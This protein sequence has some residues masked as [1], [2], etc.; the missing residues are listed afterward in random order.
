MGT[1][2]P[3]QNL[4]TWRGKKDVGDAE[5]D[6]VHEIKMLLMVAYDLFIAEFTN[7]KR[8]IVI[9]NIF[10][11]FHVFLKLRILF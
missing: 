2:G 11:Q 1:A 8:R 4:R 3:V 10:F 5:L 9:I 7:R 6:T